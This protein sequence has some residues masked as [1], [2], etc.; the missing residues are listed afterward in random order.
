MRAAETHSDQTLTS[1]GVKLNPPSL[2]AQH[3]RPPTATHLSAVVSLQVS[4]SLKTAPSSVLQAVALRRTKLLITRLLLSLL[5]SNGGR[6]TLHI[7][8]PSRWLQKDT[9]FFLRPSRHS[10]AWLSKLAGHTPGWFSVPAAASRLAST[11]GLTS[12]L[13][14]SSLWL[15]SELAR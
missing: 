4:P 6:E 12:L 13:M 8:T 5:H 9:F 1:I 14:A 10:F 3:H 15:N 11:H 7:W 2:L